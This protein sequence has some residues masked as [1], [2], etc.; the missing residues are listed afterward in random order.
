[1][2]EI[3]ML[4]LWF[5]C[6]ILTRWVNFKIASNLTA[7]VPPTMSEESLTIPDA[8]LTTLEIL[9]DPYDLD[10]NISIFCILHDSR[11]KSK[12]VV[13]LDKHSFLDSPSLV[14]KLYNHC[15]HTMKSFRALCKYERSYFHVFLSECIYLITTRHRKT[16]T[17]IIGKNSL[18]QIIQQHQPEQYTNF[19]NNEWVKLKCCFSLY[20]LYLAFKISDNVDDLDFILAIYD[21]K[22]LM[23]PTFR[24]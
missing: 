17:Q 16:A 6:I 23:V 10:V 21:K 3:A 14:V 2:M 12:Q 1:M 7:E 5:K 24:K 20:F 19:D 9:S 22:V 13:N 8:V 4:R 15:L 18:T 11:F